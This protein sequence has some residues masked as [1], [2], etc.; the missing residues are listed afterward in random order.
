M[1]RPD[2]LLERVLRGGSDA[3]IP[4]LALRNLLLRLGFQERVRGS[5][6]LFRRSDIED[7]IN[8][9]RDGHEAKAYQVR[10]VRKV[11]SKHRR[12]FPF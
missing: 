1:T 8:L 10:Q 3:S 7:R 11:L 5:H 6:H 12:R 2:D 9:Q 4:F